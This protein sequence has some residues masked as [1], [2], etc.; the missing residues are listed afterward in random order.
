MSGKRKTALFPEDK[1]RLVTV[2]LT[3]YFRRYVGYD[4]TANLEDE[5]DDITAGDREWKDVLGGSGAISKRRSKKRPIFALARCSTRSTR[6]WNRTSF[7]P[8]E[9]GGD[10]RLCPNCGEGV[11]PCAPRVRAAPSSVARTIPNAAT[12]APSAL[13]APN[14]KA[15][16][17]P[18]ASFSGRTRATTS[19]ST[20]AGSG[21][22]SSAVKSQTEEVKK[23]PR[24]GV[25]E[26]W[27]P[28]ELTLEQALKLL[29]LPRLIG[30]HP[31]RRRA[32]LGQH[33]ALWAISQ[34]RRIDTSFKGGINANLETIDEVWEIGMNR[35]VQLIDEKSRL[36]R[37]RA[38][39][40]Q[41]IERTR[42]PP[43][44]RRSCLDHGRQIRALCEMGKGERHDSQGHR[45]RQRDHGNGQHADRGTRSQ[46]RQETPR[47]EEK[48]KVLRRPRFSALELSHFS[49][50]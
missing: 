7:P 20:R 47:K 41:D 8:K 27:E 3:N 14:L 32:D 48:A 11:F 35:A 6:C 15:A 42:R 34:I 10:P 38:R 44:A 9:D 39:G 25:P 23:P 29:E 21:P 49:A 2:F 24:Q 30:P 17:R 40:C 16:S 45:P 22:T 18:R 50:T 4:F 13:R 12:P 19:G 26:G 28:A 5:L 46:K 37:A 36:T 43:R 31:G 33:R 1:G